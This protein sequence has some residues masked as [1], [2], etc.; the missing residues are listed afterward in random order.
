MIFPA[1]TTAHLLRLVTV[2]RS[3]S[4]R[5]PSYI[6][7]SPPKVRRRCSVLDPVRYRFPYGGRPCIS[8]YSMLLRYVHRH[9]FAHPNAGVCSPCRRVRVSLCATPLCILTTDH[10]HWSFT[11]YV[12]PV[13]AY[14]RILYTCGPSGTLYLSLLCGWQLCLDFCSQQIPSQ[15]HFGTSCLK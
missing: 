12:D 14:T 1:G 3:T 10:V 6:S 5:V 4:V 11:V 15:I 2:H 13:P 7:I 9:H 8:S